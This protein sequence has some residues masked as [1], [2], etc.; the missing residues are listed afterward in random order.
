MSNLKS[1]TPKTLTFDRG[2]VRKLLDHTLQAESRFAHHG[3]SKHHVPPGLVLV[4]DSGIY[5][6]SNGHHTAGGKPIAYAAEANPH[7]VAF[8]E[9]RDV[10]DA[11]FAGDGSIFLPADD[12]SAWLEGSFDLLTAAAY[13]DDEHIH[14]ELLHD[15]Y[16]SEL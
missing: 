5:L 9:W 3:Q 8:D 4:G 11:V 12:V 6:M 10:R 14:C 16:P 1:T 13:A 2:E 15:L 7:T